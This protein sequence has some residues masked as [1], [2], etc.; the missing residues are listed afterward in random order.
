ME[1][2][3]RSLVLIMYTDTESGG[4]PMYQYIFLDAAEGGAQVIA[5][6]KASDHRA[7]WFVQVV[8]C[9]QAPHSGVQPWGGSGDP[10]QALLGRQERRRPHS[11]EAG[12]GTF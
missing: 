8:G 7:S 2:V 10:G 11:R 6:A 5:V 12:G 3:A 9:E 4:A 1:G